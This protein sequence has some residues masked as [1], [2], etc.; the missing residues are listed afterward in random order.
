MECTHPNTPIL[1]VKFWDQKPK[2]STPVTQ[3]SQLVVTTA[4][5]GFHSQP[6]TTIHH[7]HNETLEQSSCYEWSALI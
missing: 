3:K 4:D 5:Y 7:T 1:D 2:F 6:C